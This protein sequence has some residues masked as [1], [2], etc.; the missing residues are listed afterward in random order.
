MAWFIQLYSLSKNELYNDLIYIISNN[1]LLRSNLKIL[2]L[3]KSTQTDT[4]KKELCSSRYR[5][6][7]DRN[8]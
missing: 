1:H 4:F 3:W 5:P 8:I 7:A 2:P 6:F